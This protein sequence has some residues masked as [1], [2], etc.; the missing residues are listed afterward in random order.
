MSNI[1]EVFKSEK[2]LNEFKKNGLFDISKHDK[3]QISIF[4]KEISVKDID[5]NQII[6]LPIFCINKK[7]F[8]PKVPVDTIS[9]NIY[10]DVFDEDKNPIGFTFKMALI[11]LY[12]SISNFKNK[13]LESKENLEK[14]LTEISLGDINEHQY[15]MLKKMELAFGLKNG[16]LDKY[17]DNSKSIENNIKQKY[18][19][20]ELIAISSPQNFIIK[21]YKYKIEDKITL[22]LFENDNNEQLNIIEE[23]VT[24]KNNNEN[25]LLNF[26]K[27]IKDI[28]NSKWDTDNII[29]NFI[30]DEKNISVIINHR[31]D[32]LEKIKEKFIEEPNEYFIPLALSMK[33][34][35]KNH[36][37]LN[38]E[39]EI[40]NIA[41]N[42]SN[43]DLILK[44]T[45]YALNK[46]L[47]HKYN[48]EVLDFEEYKNNPNIIVTNYIIGNNEC[49]VKLMASLKDSKK[50]NLIYNKYNE[51]F[52]FLE[53]KN[54]IEK[55]LEDNPVVYDFNNSFSK[56]IN[57]RVVTMFLGK[58]MSQDFDEKTIEKAFNRIINVNE[59]N[60]YELD[61]V[62]KIFNVQN[63]KNNG[64]FIDLI[65][66]HIP[67]I[68]DIEEKTEIAKFF[69][70]QSVETALMNND[71]DIINDIMNFIKTEL[72]TNSKLG[73]DFIKE[74]YE[75][76]I[77]S[78]GNKNE[79]EQ[80]DISLKDIEEY[81]ISLNKKQIEKI[82]KIKL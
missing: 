35:K 2:I 14:L 10:G 55:Y 49:N 63:S 30:K 74:M 21:T 75:L 22:D 51:K 9:R 65:K 29:N 42:L 82:S 67:T 16:I 47:N 24:K 20:S 11:T 78:I 59:R 40:I 32:I 12:S 23:N 33:N 3:S 57:K 81:S 5:T 18:N 15:L 31:I 52:E 48:N 73:N 17:F 34:L 36:N 25:E 28:E 43:E 50:L 26:D 39:N 70:K 19:M 7:Q 79:I 61:E 68:I 54:L 53:N 4:E 64:Y 72:V 76:T 37:D 77:K 27:I 58:I 60:A 1:L 62:Q 66:E 71:I 69:I 45:L 6:E 38:L 44:D 41:N 13:F 56:S 80:L 8:L 46:S